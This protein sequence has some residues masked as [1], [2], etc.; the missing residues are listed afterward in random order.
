[1]KG[2]ALDVKLFMQLNK[3]LQ[4]DLYPIFSIH[5]EKLIDSSADFV[6]LKTTFTLPAD[7]NNTRVRFYLLIS[8]ASNYLPVQMNPLATAASAYLYETPSLSFKKLTSAPKGT[9]LSQV[10]TKEEAN[11]QNG[12][13]RACRSTRISWTA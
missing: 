13:T 6:R 4:K 10:F 2:L 3:I 12:I 9:C 5:S 1:M 7:T 8:G 11:K